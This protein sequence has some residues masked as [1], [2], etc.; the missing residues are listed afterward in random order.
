MFAIYGYSNFKTPKS[1]L[2]WFR[3]SYGSLWH[4]KAYTAWSNTCFVVGLGWSSN[5]ASAGYS[6]SYYWLASDVFSGIGSLYNSTVNKA[7]T[8]KR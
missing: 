1:Y 3:E 8:L 4:V 6:R 2:G 5:W 7:K